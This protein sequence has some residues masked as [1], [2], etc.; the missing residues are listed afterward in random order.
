M[1]SIYQKTEYLSKIHFN[2]LLSKLLQNDS[3]SSGIQIHLLRIDID[4]SRFVLV[5]QE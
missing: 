2:K 4:V 5:S 3:L 1:L